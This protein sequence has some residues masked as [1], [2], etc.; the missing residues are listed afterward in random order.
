MHTNSQ[1]FGIKCGI[2]TY[3]EAITSRLCNYP[4]IDID[5]LYFSQSQTQ[6]SVDFPLR[7]IDFNEHFVFH[8]WYNISLSALK[9]LIHKLYRKFFVSLPS[10]NNLVSGSPEDVYLFFDNKLPYLKL[11]GKIAAVLHDI[12]MLR[13]SGS[14]LNPRNYINAFITK[15]DTRALLRKSSAIITVSEYSRKDIAEYFGID[16]AKIHVVYNAVDAAVFSREGTSDEKRRQIRSTYNLP[17]KY[18]LY[19]GGCMRAKNIARL[20]HAYSMLPEELR[21]Q[22]KLVITNPLKYVIKCAERCGVSESVVYLRGVPDD[23]KPAVYQMASL[24]VWPSLFEGFGLPI[25]E[26]QAS[27]VPVVS[28][29]ATSMPEV[30]GDSAML[31]DPKDTKAIASAVE[32]V[33]TDD[34]LHRDLVMKGFENIKRFSWDES[35]K[36]LHDIILSL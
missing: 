25:L 33:L 8:N 28:S 34:T 6:R 3:A 16:P 2:A 5:A 26:A 12:K 32:M 11:H 9:R 1:L 35:A 14:R 30:A 29:N 13:F 17:E 24:F 31:V 7:R 23:D 18:I 19:F 36:K 10:Y 20:I 22:Y 21:K 4:D 27:G 15:R